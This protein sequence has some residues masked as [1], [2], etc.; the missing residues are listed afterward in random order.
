MAETNKRFYNEKN[1]ATNYAAIYDSNSDA[2][3]NFVDRFFPFNNG[4][5]YFGGVVTGGAKSQA[6]NIQLSNVHI[7]YG[8]TD[9]TLAKHIQLENWL[10]DFGV[11]LAYQAGASAEIWHTNCIPEI[12]AEGVKVRNGTYNGNFGTYN[13]YYVIVPY[14]CTIITYNAGYSRSIVYGSGNDFTGKNYPVPKGYWE[15]VYDDEGYSSDVVRYWEGANLT[16]YNNEMVAAE[17]TGSEGKAMLARSVISSYFDYSNRGGQIRQNPHNRI[18]VLSQN[19]VYPQGG[20]ASC[21]GGYNSAYLTNP[22]LD[23]GLSPSRI[24]KF[25]P[26][27]GLLGASEIPREGNPTGQ[28]INA[29]KIVLAWASAVFSQVKVRAVL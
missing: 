26:E 10:S 7:Q 17:A 16:A 5:S 22:S 23:A 25:V 15:T 11:Q 8:G 24:Y 6:A 27:R 1:G 19:T 12:G 9:Y 2:Y 13:M 21:E 29:G 18:M 28:R 3:L 20:T 14:N 4:G